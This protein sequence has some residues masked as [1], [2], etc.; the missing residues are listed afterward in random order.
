MMKTQPKETRTER[1]AAFE[2]VVAE[3][4][5]RLLR[6]ATRVVND[7]NAA[8]D[9]VQDTFI[10][11]F[12]KWDK[13]LAPTPELVSWLYRVAHN[14][15]VDYIRRTSRRQALHNRHAEEQPGFSAPD[16]GESFRVSDAAA[17]AAAALKTL[18]M[19][20]QQLVILKV[21]EEKS[22][23]EI[24]AITGLKTGNVGYILHHAMR[25]MAAGL[26]KAGDH[27]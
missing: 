4:E 2:A 23:Q 21:Y 27:D 12:R 24:S 15:A 10:R 3:C 25:K 1:L 20:E 6:Y 13:P 18:T 11:L 17:R 22:Y 9:V 7:R 16:R 5:A 19:R 26:K 14:R 8:Q